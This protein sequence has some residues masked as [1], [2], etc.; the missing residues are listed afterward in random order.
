[1]REAHEPACRPCFVECEAGA[2]FLCALGR[3]IAEERLSECFGVVLG[4][5]V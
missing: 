2:V 5:V 3:G 4:V 1:M